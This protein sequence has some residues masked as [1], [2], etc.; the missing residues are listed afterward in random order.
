M[1][2]K[3]YIIG[4]VGENG[5]GKDTFTTFL[6]A[7]LAPRKIARLRFSDVLGETLTL[8]GIDKT[9]SNLQNL[10]IIMDRE[11]GKG[12]VTRAT[13]ARIKKNRFDVVVIEGVRWKTDVS[14]IK[15]F[16]N[17]FIVYVT[18]PG[19]IRYQRI[20][21]RGEKVGEKDAS[22]KQFLNEEKA[23]TELD[24]PLIGKG[25]DFKIVNNKSIDE[26]RMKV[27]EVAKNFT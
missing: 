7:K 23:K 18:A 3:K 26:F 5:S 6:R 25:A 14:M 22:Y 16:P 19:K 11:F 15:Q 27:E 8:W 1:T 10:A 20:K 24:I 12:S 2:A 17:S 9:R 13:E 4:I 21:N